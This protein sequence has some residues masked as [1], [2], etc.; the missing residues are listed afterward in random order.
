MESFANVKVLLIDQQG[1]EIFNN[2]THKHNIN[3]LKCE[4]L[5]LT[6]WIFHTAKKRK[7]ESRILVSV[8]YWT[9]SKSKV[10][11]FLSFALCPIFEIIQSVLNCQGES[12][13]LLYEN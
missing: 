2:E 4:K 6:F 10:I 7:S 1:K 5:T 13:R 12:I 9:I 3:R 11:I 8:L